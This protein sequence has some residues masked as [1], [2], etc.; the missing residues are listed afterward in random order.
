MTATRH[1]VAVA[2][3][4]QTSPLLSRRTATRW[5][6]KDYHDRFLSGTVD[7]EHGSRLE[8]PA[9]DPD[10]AHHLRGRLP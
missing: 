4:P 9:G 7:H 10:V 2:T 1:E 8:D 5:R 3:R 6:V